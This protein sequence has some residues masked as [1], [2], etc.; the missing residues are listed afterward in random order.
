MPEEA[1][2]G[3]QVKPGLPA[4]ASQHAQHLSELKDW[5]PTFTLVLVL[6]YTLHACGMTYCPAA[7]CGRYGLDVSTGPY[8]EDMWV[9]VFVQK[10]Y[11]YDYAQLPRVAPI[12]FGFAA[13]FWAVATIALRYTNFQKR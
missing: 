7:C 11:G 9:A 13:A 6:S 3:C 8:G 1:I 2:Y 4:C 5:A 12:V 10:Y